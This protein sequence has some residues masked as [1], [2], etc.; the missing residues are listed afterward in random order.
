MMPIQS[1]SYNYYYVYRQQIWRKKIK[2]SSIEARQLLAGARNPLPQSVYIGLTVRAVFHL[3]GILDSFL[4]WSGQGVTLSAH[5]HLLLR[6]RRHRTVP[7]VCHIPRRGDTGTTF[8]FITTFIKQSWSDF[9]ER[10]RLTRLSV[11]DYDAALQQCDILLAKREEPLFYNEP[12]VTKG[13]L[14]VIRCL[15]IRVL[16]A[17]YFSIIM[18]GKFWIKSTQ[19]TAAL[20]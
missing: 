13:V 8:P 7:P 18:L 10:A 14:C 3:M 9:I 1:N 4:G 11:Y 2:V 12:P 16:L 19:N 17:R 15:L 6:L 20:T 5:L